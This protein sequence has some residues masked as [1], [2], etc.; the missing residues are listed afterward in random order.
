MKSFKTQSKRVLD[1]M[2]NSIYTHKEIFLR[3]LLSN[4]SDAIDKL[5]YKGLKEGLTGLTRNDFSIRIDADKEARTL[6]ISDNGIGM[7]EKELENN[8][9]TIAQSGSLAFK[10][11]NADAKEKEDVNVI[12]QFGVGFY[13]AFMVSDKVEVISK[14]FGETEAH[15]WVSS[16][17]E[18]YDV[19]PAER[20]GNGTTIILHL[21]PDTDDDKFSDYLEEYRIR[22]LVKKYSDY[23]RYPIVTAVTKY[24]EQT[25][26]ERKEGKAR[27]SYKEDETLNSMIPLWKKQKSEITKEEY[28]KFYKDT[29]YDYEDPLRVIH[30][31][32]EGAV[33]YKALLYIPAKAPYNYYSKNY[34]K[35]LKLYTDGVMIMDRCEE[36]LPDCFSF[37]KGLVDSE[38]TLNI[39]RETIQHDRQLKL[40]ASNLEKKIKSELADMLKNDRENYEKFYGEFGLQLRYGLYSGWGMNKELLQDLILFRSVKTE[41]YV[42]LKEY[43]DGMATDQKFIYY[44]NGK[45]VDAVK[46]LPQSEKVLES[47]YDIL[48]FSD[49]VDE[50]AIKML[51]EYEGKSFKNILGEDLGLKDE[52][53]AQNEEDKEMLTAIKDA[54]G[55][56]V[57]KVKVSTVL[58]SHPVCLSS[59]GEVSLEMEKVLSQ[60]PNAQ[61]GVK[62]N[63]VLEINGNHPIY[64]KLKKVYA[65]NHEAVRD[66]ADILYA[67]A[68]LIAGLSVDKPTEIA[69][70][71]FTLLA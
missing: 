27:E 37:V 8:L 1:L 71:I 69:D 58:K 70:K 64:E 6:T 68:R 14:A 43:L 12:G 45:S 40:I 32:T 60:M 65:E 46:A 51:G 3:E 62:A 10:E 26:E 31:S 29:F 20:E 25:E 56:K 4:C 54:L 18:G 2:I 67:A 41:K 22:Q 21:K 38:L 55:D 49:D 35:G 11:E 7:T 48:C 30:F 15:K 17:T 34:E 47:G 28:D 53:N 5:Y 63:K 23:I 57:S 24:K 13:S 42:T 52:D 59:E 50:F 19:L 66:Y 16:G 44:G 39:S 9:G 61:E 33:S 36:L